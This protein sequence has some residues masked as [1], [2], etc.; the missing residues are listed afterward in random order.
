MKIANRN[1]IPDKYKWKLEDMISSDEEWEKLFVETQKLGEEI[2]KYDGKLDRAESILECLKFD[3]SLNEKLE[4]L[5]V[6]AKMRKDEDCS[7]EKYLAMVERVNNLLVE[8]S[9]KSAYI[10]PQ[11]SANSKEFLLEL[12]SRKEFSDYSYTLSLTAKNKEHTLSTEEE[13]LLAKAGMFSGIFQEAFGMFDNLDV[14]FK[15]FKDGEGNR[16]EMSHG[17]YG[18]MLQSQNRRDRKKAFESM[19]GAY[20]DMI[21]TIASIYTGNVKKN[22]FY[23]QARK[24]N[25]CLERATSGE[26]VPVSVYERLV[27]CIDGSLEGLH[28]YLRY[29]KKQLGCKELHMYDLH[30]PIVQNCG[31]GVEYEEACKIVKNALAP[32]G[33]EYAEL[34]DEAFTKGWI[35]VRENKGKRS[36]AYSWGCYGVH[37]YVLL[38]YQKT[39]HDIFTIAHELGHAMHSYYSNAMQPYAKAEY[40]IFVAE[41]AST[42]NEV[43]LLRYMLSTAKKEEKK[44]LLSYLLDMF[45]TTVFRQ[46]QFAEFEYTA[47]KYAEEGKPL[48]A[49]TLCDIYYGLNEKYYKTDGVVNDE[50]IKYEWARI[51]HFYNAFYVYKYATGLISALCIADNILK[52]GETA[53]RDYK[54]FLKAGGSMP[55][56]EI[57]KLAGVDLTC[58]QPYAQAMKIFEDTLAELIEIG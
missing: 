41:V 22:V 3:D 16:V 24:Y 54:K 19:F 9:Q 39:T 13:V 31:D 48:N 33:E 58:E 29:R 1:E 20:R 52:N 43:L 21:N 15:P 35:D 8:L 28:K 5:Y 38:N 11:L 53:V 42:V 32:M 46:T 30:V 36:G 49:Q 50:L 57:L 6:Y 45:R 26:D 44:Y 55:P 27:K 10:S 51:P 34:L 18:L 47:H 12:A 23:S 17:I 2:G 14:S 56:V 4:R 37:P 25:S 7:R 40:K